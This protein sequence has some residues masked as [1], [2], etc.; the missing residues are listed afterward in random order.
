V[1]LHNRVPPARRL[2]SP[3][4]R[5]RALARSLARERRPIDADDARTIRLLTDET[6]AVLLSELPEEQRVAIT[7]HILDDRACAEVAGTTQSSEPA[8]RQRVSRALQTLRRRMGG[9]S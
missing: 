9:R 3:R 1:A 5:R 4:P 7:A 8:V 2:P 6:A